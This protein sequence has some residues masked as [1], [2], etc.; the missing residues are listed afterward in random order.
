MHPHKPGKVRRVLSGAAKFLS[1]S[2]NNAFLTGPD[3]LQSLI[4]ILFR[5]RQFPYD[6]SAEIEGMFLQV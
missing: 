6:V 2:L 1:Q 5:F 3:L 4:H